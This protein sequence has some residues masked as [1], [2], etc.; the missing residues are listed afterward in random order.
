M[1]KFIQGCFLGIL[2]FTMPMLV[3]VYVT[4]GF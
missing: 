4:G 2:C 3:Y 1:I